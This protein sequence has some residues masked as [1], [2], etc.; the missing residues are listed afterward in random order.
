MIELT[1]RQIEQVVQAAEGGT[2]W[3]PLL[4]NMDR[5][6]QISVEKV[7]GFSNRRLSRSLLVGLLTFASLPRDGSYIGNAEAARLL[8]L[9]TSTSFRYFAT[10]E[11]VGL[12]ER[13]ASN[14]K[15][16]LVHLP[17]TAGKS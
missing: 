5:V 14:R 10:L 11:A 6:P 12:V 7:P 15:Y 2:S 8:G 9:H 16:R 13:H 3:A 17:D 4:A 1:A